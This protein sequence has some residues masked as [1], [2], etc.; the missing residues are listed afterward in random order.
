[1]PK[2]AYFIS[3][4]FALGLCGNIDYYSDK[5]SYGYYTNTENSGSAGPLARYYFRIYKN[6]LITEL[7]YN[8]GWSVRTITTHSYT[9]LPSTTRI[10]HQN[11]N[12]YA[13][14]RVLLFY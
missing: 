7:T 2:T 11:F 13:I 12:Q 1:M 4:N 10:F 3:K 6:A 5:I 8:Y 14:G 9:N